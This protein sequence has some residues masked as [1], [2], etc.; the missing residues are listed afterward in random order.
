MAFNNGGL[1]SKTS[2]QAVIVDRSTP[3]SGVV[4]A[5][6]AFPRTY[7]RN[8]NKV[9]NSTVVVTWTGFMDPESGVKQ[10]SW[11]IGTDR[12]K[13]DEGASDAYTVV[14]P[15]ESVGGAIITNLTLVGNETYF[16]CVRVTNGVGLKRTDCSPGMLVVLGQLSAGVVSDGPITSSD[17]V[18][19]QLD[20]KALWAHWEGFEDPV[21]DIARYEW[22]IR[23]QLPNP[24]GSD[25]C[26]WSFMEISH[27]KTRASRFH[28][29]TL[30][31][32]TKYYVTVNAENTRGDNVM[33]SSDGV[34]VDRT[35]PIGKVNPSRTI[36][37]KRDCV[38]NFTFC[39]SSYLVD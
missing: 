1:S 35:P 6:Y 31:H 18:D 23:D 15:G 12:Q 26:K 3:I 14:D 39:S 38:S 7:D 34:V 2:S 27:L 20:D 16:V 13:L 30:L 28:N 36:I 29:L 17:D 19:F 33:S 37:G 11:A 4:A 5:Y 10:T 32:G 25:L 8:I 24:S 9:P 21:F 22:C